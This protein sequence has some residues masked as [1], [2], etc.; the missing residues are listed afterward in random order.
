MLQNDFKSMCMTKKRRKVSK[1]GAVQLSVI[2]FK[3]G[4]KSAKN[5]AAK[6]EDGEAGEVINNLNCVPKNVN[7]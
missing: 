4:I 7:K 5:E 1:S 6:T 2:N 3:E